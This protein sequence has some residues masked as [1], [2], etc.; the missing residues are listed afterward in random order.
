M[1]Q[2]GTSRKLL[3]LPSDEQRPT[4]HVLVLTGLKTAEMELPRKVAACSSKCR[5]PQPAHHFMCKEGQ[6]QNNVLDQ[7]YV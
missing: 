7:V 5:S 2:L 3:M 6:R 1:L 4:A